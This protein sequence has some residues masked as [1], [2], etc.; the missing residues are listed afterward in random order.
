M[1]KN[2]STYIG[3]AVAAAI[4]MSVVYVENSLI[5][6]RR[7]EEKTAETVAQLGKIVA[8]M[9]KDVADGEKMLFLIKTNFDTFILK[10]DKIDSKVDKLSGSYITTAYF[11]RRFDKYELI[12]NQKIE[13]LGNVMYNDRLQQQAK[14]DG[15]TELIRYIL[16]GLG[17]RG[18]GGSSFHQEKVD[19]SR[20]K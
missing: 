10:L 17:A 3:I 5:K 6:A 2:L 7:M 13:R 9:Q 15:N 18:F 20:V 12:T 14:I 11:D 8:V 4:T 1:V 19:L 16:G